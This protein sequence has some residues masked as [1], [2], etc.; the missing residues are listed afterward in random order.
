MSSSRRR[1][2]EIATGTKQKTQQRHWHGLGSADECHLSACC[3]VYRDG[4]AAAPVDM[5]ADDALARRDLESN[6]L[7]RAD[8]RRRGLVD[9]ADVRATAISAEAVGAPDL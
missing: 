2:T 5:T 7:T 8:R 9:N 6:R 4:S 1:E 3:D